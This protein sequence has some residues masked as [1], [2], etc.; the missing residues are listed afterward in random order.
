MISNWPEL[1]LT[2]QAHPEPKRPIAAAL[3]FSL[4]ASKLVKFEVMTFWMSPFGAP[5]PFF[6][7]RFQKSEWLACPPPLFRTAVLIASGTAAQLLAS[8]CSI[9]LLARSGADS[10]ALLRF[11]T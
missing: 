3:S 5:P 6:D 10:R 4:N 11:V 8:N 7:I 2:S 1:P 9:D